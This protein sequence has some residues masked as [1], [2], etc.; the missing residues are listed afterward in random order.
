MSFHAV[1]ADCGRLVKLGWLLFFVFLQKKGVQI[2]FKL[3]MEAVIVAAG[4]MDII[5]DSSINIRMANRIPYIMSQKT[6]DIGKPRLSL[7]PG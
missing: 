5:L 4:M 3:S 6:T 2:V 1:K 7:L